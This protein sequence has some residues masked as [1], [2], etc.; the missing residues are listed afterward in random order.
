[1]TAKSKA[2]THLFQADPTVPGRV[3]PRRP[4]ATPVPYCRCGLA[5]DHPCH[6]LPAAP[7]DVQSLAAGEKEEDR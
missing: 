3:D 1:M 2:R 6:T 5:E 7:A 4:T